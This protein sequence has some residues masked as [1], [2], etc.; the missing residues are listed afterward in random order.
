M[1]LGGITG[2]FEYIFNNIW[3]TATLSLATKVRNIINVLSFFWI[4]RHSLTFK[5]LVSICSLFKMPR[6][7]VSTRH[8]LNLHNQIKKKYRIQWKD[9]INHKRRM[10]YRNRLGRFQNGLD[11]QDSSEDRDKS[12]PR[13]DNNS[14][15]TEMS[16]EQATIARKKWLKC[17]KQYELEIR[18]YYSHVCNCCGRIMRQSQLKFL[19]KKQLKID[20]EIKKK[21]FYVKNENISKFCKTCASY[22][23]KGKIPRVA[24]CNGLDFPKVHK[25]ISALNRIEERLLAPRHVFQSLWTHQGPNGQFKAKGGIVNVPVDIDTSVK[26]LPRKISDSHIIHI[27]IAR[28]MT[29]V[30]D[31]MSGVVRPRLLYDAA[32]RFVSTPLA[33]EEGIK[34]NFKWKCHSHATDNFDLSDDEHFV[35]NA[36]YETMLTNDK[37]EQSFCRLMD[38]GIRIAPAENYS[39]KS[40]LFD[41]NCEYLAFPKVFGGYKMEPEHDGNKLPYSDIV[42][43][44]AL[45]YDRRVAERGDLLLFIAKKLEILKLYNNIGICVRKKASS[46]PI[47]AGQMLNSS[48]ISGLVQHNDGYKVLRG[49]RSSPAHWQEEKTKLMAQIR[50]F[51]LPTFFVTLSAAD[52]RWPELLVALKLSVDKETVSEEDTNK[53][54]S[55]ERAR[56]IQ[57]DPITC[58]LHFDQRFKALKKT[59]DNDSGPFLSHKITHYY[60]RIE[61]QQRG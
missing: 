48:Y 42:K 3:Q 12:V 10:E 47:T 5:T 9:V 58:A 57:K 44:M 2:V 59:W 54:S 35:Q 40:V 34:L 39:P 15:N 6:L 17:V 45:R 29:Y 41:D 14:E 16:P 7:K 1:Y 28:R 4:H 38:K 19:E 37:D 60:H 23:E 33:K 49:V 30:K 8:K 51:G 25:S 27:R 31:F 36:I 52:T 24:L 56:L 53:F 55:A 43:S 32:K 20:E 13:R 11:A 50:Q 26:E 18:Q 21:V 46:N 22:I 61:F